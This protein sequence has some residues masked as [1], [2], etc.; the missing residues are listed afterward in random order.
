MEQ[1]CRSL[2]SELHEV[3]TAR[4]RAVE[5]RTA[6]G[7]VK[8]AA[9]IAMAAVCAW[10][11]VTG[12]YHLVF[13]RQLRTDPITAALSVLITTKTKVDYVDPKVLSQYLSLLFIGFLVANSMR[14]F[15]YALNRLFFAV[16][17]GGGGTSTFLVLFVAEM[18]GLYFLSSVLLIRNS[19]PDRYRGFIDE[20]MGADNL[21]FSFYQNFYDL[22]FLTSSLL[23]CMLLWASRS[24]AS[25]GEH[26]GGSK[27]D[28]SHRTSLLCGVGAT[29]DE[30][31]QIKQKI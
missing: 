14:N 2:F 4:G 10:R 13:K 24:V 23:T 30:D 27:Y 29:T 12:L 11:V 9:G 17:G 31:L 1:V 25:G 21:E 20:A 26:G 28:V 22:I 3:K 19:L 8:N 7:K 6:W 15:V 5:S 18:Q 16:G